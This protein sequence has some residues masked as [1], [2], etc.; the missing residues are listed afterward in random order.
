M[1]C[2]V[3]QSK[4]F[5]KSE[6]EQTDVVEH[7]EFLQVNINQNIQIRKMIYWTSIV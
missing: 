4:I 7:D 3:F 1:K 6:L 2:R 5:Q